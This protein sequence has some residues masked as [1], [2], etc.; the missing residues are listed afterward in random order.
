MAEVD[1]PW[2]HA[3]LKDTGRSMRELARHMK[4]DPS[5]VSRIFSGSRKMTMDEVP[6]IA[7]FLGVTA[8]EVRQ[9]AGVAVFENIIE[10]LLVAVIDE[11]GA[12]QMVPEPRSLPHSVVTKAQLLLSDRYNQQVDGAQVR[13]TTGALSFFDDAVLFFTRA[14]SVEQAAIGSLSICGLADGTLKLARVDRVRK[15]GEALIILPDGK[16]EDV[17]LASATPIIAMMP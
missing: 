5:A 7:A 3:K 13:A 10:P 8:W 9:H 15:T 11:N 2:F 1:G 12:V 4:L 6:Q 14:E 17:V 16:V